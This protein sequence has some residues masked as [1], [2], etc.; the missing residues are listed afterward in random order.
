MA[1]EIRLIEMQEETHFAVL[2]ALVGR[3]ACGLPLIVGHATSVTP[4]AEDGRY[5]RPVA[6]SRSA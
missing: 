6:R 5:V 2:G 3:S 4:V 1:T